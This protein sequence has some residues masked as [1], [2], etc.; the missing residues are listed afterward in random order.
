MWDSRLGC[1]RA[2]KMPALQKLDFIRSPFLSAA[3]ATSRHPRIEGLDLP[4]GYFLRWMG[5]SFQ[6]HQHLTE[7]NPQ[8][9][10]IVGGGYI[11]LEMADALTLHGLQVTL[12][13][14]S[15]TVLKT[16]HASFGRRVADE[17]KW[18]G[19]TVETGIAS[20]T[21]EYR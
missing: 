17:L 16:V 15:P 14:H 19:V 10:I 20:I 1:P 8:S 2:G 5:D 4:G 12:V 18:H 7:Q 13:E 9:A 3:L 11:G 6:V 21:G